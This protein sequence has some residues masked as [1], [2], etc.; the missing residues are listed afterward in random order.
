MK[1]KFDKNK[2][3]ITIVY[4]VIALILLGISFY[5]M[6]KNK[7]I[8]SANLEINIVF[9]ISIVYFVYYFIKNKKGKKK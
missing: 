2:Y 3:M 6:I 9:G 7:S 1:K 4:I 5:K 8:T